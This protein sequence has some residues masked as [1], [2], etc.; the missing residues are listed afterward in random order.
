MT[1]SL[2]LALLLAVHLLGAVV[3]VGGLAFAL[4]VLTPAAAG[5]DAGSRVALAGRVYK[6][7]F[8]ILWHAMPLILLTGYAMVFGY[9]GGFQGVAWPV[10]VMHLF[11]LIMAAVFVYMFFGPWAAMRAAQGVGDQAKLVAQVGRI[12]M[13]LR[14]NLVL[15]LITVVIAAFAQY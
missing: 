8:L 5:M 13:L 6:R 14:V 12:R 10:H 7:F 15:G 2:I 3:W 4:L 1:S 11:G 9:L